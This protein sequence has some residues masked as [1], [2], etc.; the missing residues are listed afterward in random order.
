M[1][2]EITVNIDKDKTDVGNVSATWTD[3]DIV[4]GVFSFS[5]RIKAN[6]T[7]ADVFITQVIAARDAW[8]IWQTENNIKAVWALGRLNTAD[9]KV[10]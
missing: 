2:W 10:V 7:G 6:V 9:P 1:A 4:L 3:P 5:R 8:Q